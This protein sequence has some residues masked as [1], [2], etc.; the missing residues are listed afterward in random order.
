VTAVNTSSQVTS[1][2]IAPTAWA[3]ANSCCPAVAMPPHSA[4]SSES[5]FSKAAIS[6]PGM[7]LYGA[8]RRA[9]WVSQVASASPGG[10]V[11]A[12]SAASLAMR[13]VPVP[14]SSAISASRVGK[15]R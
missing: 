15:C 14:T 10:S 3:A 12:S 5:L 11:A 4:P 1:A 8:H 6:E 2:R 7:P 9:S 13:W